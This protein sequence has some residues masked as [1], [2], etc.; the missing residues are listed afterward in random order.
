MGGGGQRRGADDARLL[1]SVNL[2]LELFGRCDLLWEPARPSAVTARR[3]SGRIT[4]PV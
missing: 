2:F 1:H 3:P 4:A